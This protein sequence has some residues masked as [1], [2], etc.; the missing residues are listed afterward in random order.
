MIDYSGVP[1]RRLAERLKIV[2]DSFIG[3]PSAS[4]P[5]A[6]GSVEAAKAAYRFFDNQ[7]VTPKAIIGAQAKASWTRVAKEKPTVVIRDL[8]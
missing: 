7:R 8:G 1:D 4:I 5:Q 6:S 2:V 3:Q